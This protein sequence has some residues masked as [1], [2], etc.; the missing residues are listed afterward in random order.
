MFVFALQFYIDGLFVLVLMTAIIA[1]RFQSVALAIL[2]GLFY[3]WCGIC[4]HNYFHMRDN[5]RMFY[6][7][8]L[9][10][11]YRTWRITHALSH[12]MYPN[13]LLDYELTGF[14]PFLV[15]VPDKRVKNF[16]QRYLSYIY[17]PVFYCFYFLRY[18]FLR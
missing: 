10:M 12:H 6:F 11:S 18:F 1:Q 2:C 3:T 13:S 8:L 17:S 15:F 7:N 9:F 4:A 16:A 5:Y 14:E